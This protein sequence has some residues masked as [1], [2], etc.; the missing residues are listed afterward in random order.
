SSRSFTA[1]GTVNHTIKKVIKEI[2]C[3]LFEHEGMPTKEFL[4][5]RRYQ[6]LELVLSYLVQ[7][8]YSQVSQKRLSEKSGISLPL[9]NETLQWLEDLEICHQIKTRRHGKIAPSI[10]VLSLHT[11]YLKIIEYFKQKWAYTIDVFATFTEFLSKEVRE[12]TN[13]ETDQEEV[14]S[15]SICRGFDVFAPAEV[16][17][18]EQDINSDEDHTLE[19]RF[20]E[21]DKYMSDAQ[22]KLYLYILTQDTNITEKDAYTIALRMPPDVDWEVRKTFEE[23][24][25]C[26]Q[27]HTADVSTPAHFIKMFTKKLHAYRKIH[28]EKCTIDIAFQ[29]QIDFKKFKEM[30]APHS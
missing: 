24:V 5:P 21:M 12:N 25:R 1:K 27:F 7:E 16:E 11:N 4:T 17:V 9:I 6:A 30:L 3:I 20:Q 28:M 18:N 14:C 22:K 23:C 8:G 29:S 19:L 10:Y 2:D 26:F 13:R 15:A